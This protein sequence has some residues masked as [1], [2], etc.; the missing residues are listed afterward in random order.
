M[1]CILSWSKKIWWPK[2]VREW[3]K[4]IKNKNKFLTFY[5]QC[6]FIQLVN[7]INLLFISYFW[8]LLSCKC[9]LV[10]PR[11]SFT[12]RL[13]C[14]TYERD[15]KFKQQPK[16]KVYMYIHCT[17]TVYIIF[18]AYYALV[19]TVRLFTSLVVFKKK[20]KRFVFFGI[21]CKTTSKTRR[22][23]WKI[24]NEK[25][26]AYAHILLYF[27]LSLVLEKKMVVHQI[28]KRNKKQ[29][30]ITSS[31]NCNMRKR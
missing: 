11:N 30:S 23:M 20:K 18:T 1:K 26:H 29:K 14:I 4:C 16:K 28:K 13:H 17:C 27:F 8:F 7:C 19:I 10:A 6:A 15:I 5:F 2:R 3:R 21:R 31:E 25:I 22:A 9:D 24:I 12:L